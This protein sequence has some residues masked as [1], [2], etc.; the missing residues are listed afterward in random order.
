MLKK[1]WDL[2]HLLE[3]YD[4]L[5]EAIVKDIAR[6]PYYFS[7]MSPNMSICDFRDFLMFDEILGDKFH[8]LLSYASLRLSSDQKDQEARMM[9]DRNTKLALMLNDASR[10]IWHWFKGKNVKG[11]KK[12]DDANCKRLSAA[13]KDLQYVLYLV[14]KGGRFTLS[15]QEELLNSRK[16][17]TGV[18]VHNDLYMLISSDMKFVLKCPGEPQ[19]TY[20]TYAEISSLAHSPESSKRKYAYKAILSSYRKKADQ[21]FLIYK[22]I[23]NDWVNMASLRGYKT[24]ISARNFA[25]EVEDSAVEVLL[26][27]VRDNRRVF[28]RYFAFKARELGKKKLSRFDLY[29]PLE[30]SERKITYEKAKTIVLETFGNFSPRFKGMAQKVFD[31]E[32]IDIFPRKSKSGGAFCLTPCPSVIPYMMINF[33]GKMDDVYTLAHELGHAVHSQYASKHLIDS[34]GAS[35]A[36]SETA[37]TLAETLV[38]ERLYS[39]SS[40]SAKKG[41]LSAKISSFYATIMRQNYFVLF[42]LEAH[43]K[44]P[45]GITETELS[46]I[47]IKGL[48]EQFGDTIDIDPAFRH[49]WLC[50]P[51]IFSSPFYC[52]SYSFGDLLALALFARYR[53]D[54]SFAKQIET[55][56]EYG[57][58]KEP[59]KILEE[60]GV[61]ISSREFWQ[62]SFNIISE[63]QERLERL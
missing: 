59:K 26:D 61:D 51:H 23:V 58:S 46:D 36:L 43:K 45:K 8:R 32:H 16:N 53:K 18:Q 22:A 10:S 1:T 20:P 31:S 49:E 60:I 3:S 5:H 24:P 50:I 44:I 19:K 39:Q 27:T 40:R 7:K 38:F 33:V 63:W 17:S 34:Q 35:L 42:E 29:A 9:D 41:M 47:Y 54:P 57:G 30:K 62:G 11:K 14:R 25:N 55:V 6:F 52:Y 15:Q 21:L 12:L 48:H 2:T 56:L 4:A 28:Q 37:S 13:V